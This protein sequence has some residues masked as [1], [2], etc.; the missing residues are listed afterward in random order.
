[1]K[2]TM[3]ALLVAGISLA[4][5]GG[6]AGSSG[7]AL[8]TAPQKGGLLVPATATT[9]PDG[10]LQGTGSV[11]GLFTGGFTLDTGTSHGQVHIYT[12]SS[13]VFTGAKPSTGEQVQVAGTGSWSTSVTATSVTQV[14]GA[15]PTA[16]P[17]AA[18]PQPVVIGTPSPALVTTQGPITALGTGRFQINSGSPH[19]YMWIT[20][21]SST[22][23]VG[24]TGPVVGQYAQMSGTGSLSSSPSAVIVT[25]TSAAPASTTVTGTIVAGT[26]Y[27]FTLNVDATHQAVP[28]VINGTSVIAGGILEGGSLASVT[29]TGSSSSSMTAVQIVVTNPT[30]PPTP[31]PGPIA[32]THVLTAD[33]LAGANGTTSVA[34]STAAQY[35]TWAQTDVAHANAIA[36]AGIK[37]QFYADPNRTQTGDVLLTSD[38][39]TYAHDCNNNRVTDVFNNRVTQNVM[40]PTS[41]TMQ[42]LYSTKI[43]AQLATTHFDAIYQDD[44][45]ALSDIA[46]PFTPGLPCNYTDSAWLNGQATLSNS[47]PRPVIFNGLNVLHGHSPSQSISLLSAS[48]VIGGNYE[49]C[50][51]DDASAKNNGWLWLA[52]ENT[53]LQ[54]NALQK[55]FSCQERNTSD[56]SANTDARLYA[57]ASFLLT[58]NPQNDMIW[59][60]FGTPSNFHVFPEEQLVVMNPKVAAPGDVSGLQIS[61]GAYGREYQD[62]YVA[63]NFVGPC[64][65]AVNPNAS[66]S[67]PFP[68]PQYGHSLVL[69]GY[70]ST[71]GGT[72]AA[73]GAAPPT[74]LPAMEAEIVFP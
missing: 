21:T 34:W 24:G 64:A 18:T 2:R 70:G 46:T 71:D 45:G 55:I 69:S 9:N 39:T 11:T 52:E 30:P 48:N 5:C 25:M 65:I 56:G 74:Y 73:N 31:T 53:E 59:E 6:G 14:V 72:M 7:S 23:F 13:T 19:G 3:L 60:A 66:G 67:V 61:G 63:G 36:A 12:N 26:S 41:A 42:T 10:T 1:M 27:G 16:T 50:Y 49:H 44:N 35:L 40:D 38:Q 22:T 37:T 4:A 28:I 47:A 17:L 51:S 8:P 20:Y 68:Y 54:V 15:S 33:Y 58:Y 29:G 62:C 57:Y 32:Q 43:G